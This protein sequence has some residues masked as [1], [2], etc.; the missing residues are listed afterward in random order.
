[1]PLTLYDPK[2]KA[3][4]LKAVRTT[5]RSGKSWDD[6]YEAAQALHYTGT[7]TSLQKMYYLRKRPGRKKGQKAFAHGTAVAGMGGDLRGL[8]AAVDGL[9]TD[10]LRSA[11]D[12]A[13]AVLQRTR[14]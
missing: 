2:D 7:R 8:Q 1:M 14:G 10:R 13:I 6:A 12:R 9:V 5:L 3:A 11:L 4:F